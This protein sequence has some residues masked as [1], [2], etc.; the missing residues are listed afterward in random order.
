MGAA[1]FPRELKH[2]TRYAVCFLLGREDRT[3]TRGPARLRII[4]SKTKSL[5]LVLACL[6][7]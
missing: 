2:I 6:L 7:D 5:S 1:A 4:Q 3:G